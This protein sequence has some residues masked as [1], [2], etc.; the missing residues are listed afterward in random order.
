MSFR[1]EQEFEDAL[2]HM[3]VTQKGWNGG[4]IKNPTEQDL[5]DN[6]ARILFQMNNETDRLNGVPL[7]KEEMDQ[8]IREIN[9]L[10]TP[11]LK[12]EFINGQSISIKRENPKDTL[13]YGKEVS[14]KLFDKREIAGGDSNY[15]IVQQPRFAGESKV[16][17]D[18]R[19]DFILLIN[20]MP[21]IHVELKRAGTPIT[22]AVNQIQRYIHNGVFSN[23][24]YSLVQIFVAMTPDNMRYFANPGTNPSSKI[25]YN[26][27]FEWANFDNETITDWKIIADTFMSIP[28]AHQLVGYYTV[29]DKSDGV[30]KVLRSYQIYAVREIVDRLYRIKWHERSQLG[31]YIW[32][33]TGSGKTLTSF[34]AAELISS[35]R[36]AEKVVFLMDR[37]ELGT[38]TLREFKS[39]ANFEDQVQGTQNTDDLF[40]K[41]RSN[42]P[43]DSLVVTSIQ[44]MSSITTEEYGE[45]TIGDIQN[46]KMVIIIDEAHRSTFGD[47]LYTIKETFPD[48]IFFGFTGTPIH[49]ENKRK[50]STTATIFGQELHRY[51]L[52]DG[53]RDNNVLGFDITQVSTIDYKDLR[54]KV[55]LFEANAKDVAEVY[56][57]P[58]KTKIYNHYMDYKKVGMLGYKDEDDKYHKG[59]E[60]DYLYK[61][62]FEEEEHR[63]QVVKDIEENWT[64]LSMNSKYSAILA[65]SSREEAIQYYRLLKNNPMDIKVTV[66]FDSNLDESSNSIFIEDG[67]A[68]ILQD[69]NELYQ[70]TYTIPNHH[71]FKQDLSQR[72]A[73]KGSYQNIKEEEVIH[74]VIVVD[75]LLTGYDSKWINT[76]Y[77]DKRME[78]Q[79]II[80]AFSRTNRLNGPTKPFGSIRYYRW[81][82]RMEKNTNDA[83]ESYSGGRSLSL[84]VDK[85]GGNL[86]EMNRI[87]EDMHSVFSV[88]RIENFERLPKGKESRKKFAQLFSSFN[89]S[90]D[91][92][93]IQGFSWGVYE[94]ITRVSPYEPEEKVAVIFTEEMYNAWLLRYQELAS[95]AGKVEGIDDL[96]FDI[97]YELAEKSVGRIDYDY[98]NTN[99]QRFVNSK[100]SGNKEGQ[101][102]IK[103]DLHRFF[104]TLTAEQQIYANMVINDLEYGNLVV[105]EGKDFTDYIN[106]YRE[107]SEDKE[108]ASVIEALS[109]D[110][111]K[112][113]EMLNL[114][115]TKENIN[116]YG[117][118]DK[119]K[120]TINKKQ[121]KFYI[122]VVLNETMKPYEVSITADRLLRDFL[123]EGGFDIDEYLKNGN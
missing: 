117:R 94:Y 89:Q 65:T 49:E 103:N 107:R 77:V 112:L 41:L 19:G 96:P 83:V 75:Q 100:K 45:Q 54:E 18:N 44:K 34:K 5:L 3:L 105:Q 47:M 81:I 110:E 35:Y 98:L 123:L 46:K 70:K 48:A 73:Q 99:F 28:S 101:E 30:L 39:F 67:L 108:V 64:H 92:A 40:H 21:V 69:Y 12:N 6:W 109:V 104:A 52:S 115:I 82:Y 38:Q 68:E 76:L 2:I 84:F 43:S 57:N 63:K 121:A 91:A 97:N 102:R 58:G 25:N 71:L 120:G 4:V 122:E 20:G 36:I 16:K 79:N 15:Q 27:V 66:L 116:E 62:Y 37:V 88:D 26:Y 1:T 33:T 60:S 90:L 80:Q 42:K 8:I 119:L 13:H 78:F 11:L 17:G 114:K 72:L 53:I 32:H 29:A 10:N 74:L 23:G 14:L 111:E 56:E 87:T 31:G 22:N 106:E 95:D 85:L 93:L 51:S 9:N 118:F 59:I 24:I 50:D 7:I 55:A 61:G 113:R 86:R